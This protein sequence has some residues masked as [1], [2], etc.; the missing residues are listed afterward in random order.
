MIC[1]L[2]SD[3]TGSSFFVSSV[4]DCCC[5]LVSDVGVETVGSLPSSLSA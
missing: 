2:G 4:E 1:I 5:G 3:D